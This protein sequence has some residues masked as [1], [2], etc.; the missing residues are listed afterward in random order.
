MALTAPVF[1]SMRERNP[2]AVNSYIVQNGE[3]IY[4]GALVGVETVG[5]TT[6]RLVNW[7]SSSGDLRFKGIAIPNAA[8]VVGTSGTVRCPVNEG[9]P[10]LESVAVTG[11]TAQQNVG[12]SVY[13]SDENTFTRTATANVGAIGEITRYISGTTCDVQLYTPQEYAGVDDYGQV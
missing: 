10:V 1:Y 5:V 6:G 11:A 12:D 9:G 8:S 7:N 4:H 13:A 2:F 3:T